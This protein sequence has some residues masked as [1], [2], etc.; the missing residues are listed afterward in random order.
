MRV[1]RLVA[2]SK[3]SSEITRLLHRSYRTIQVHRASLLQKL[4]AKNPVALIRRALEMR[5]INAELS[6]KGD[7]TTRKSKK[8]R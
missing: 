3:T 2:E 4:N 5:L 1:L 7:K 6:R 8:K